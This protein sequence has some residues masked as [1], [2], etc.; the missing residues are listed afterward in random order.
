M[1]TSQYFIGLMSGT[2][3]D[4]LDVALVEVQRDGKLSLIDFICKPLPKP[5]SSALASMSIAQQV[6]LDQLGQVSVA[7]AKL[8]ASACLHIIE[9]NH[10]L[11]E[12]ITAIGSH[13]V[14]VRHRPNSEHSFS[15]QITDPNTLAALTG[16]D[17]IADFRGM[18]IAHQG[19]GAPLVPKFHQVLLGQFNQQFSTNTDAILANLGG[20]ANISVL[21][22]GQGV[23]G[24]DTGPANTLMNLWCQQHL[25]Q[26]FDVDGEWAATGKVC[27][28]LL[29]KMLQ[30]A[31]FAEGWPKS[32]GKEKFNLAWLQGHLSQLEQALPPQDVQAT[33][34]MLTVQ[35]LA[36]EVTKF[37]VSHLYLCGGGSQNPVLVAA[38]KDALPNHAIAT[39]MALGVDAD[40]LEAMAFAWFAY[41][42]VHQIP[43]NVPEATGATR[44][45]VLGAWYQGSSVQN[46]VL[47]KNGEGQ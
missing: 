32:T 40:A 25:N 44:A 24:Y 26:D 34:L 10:L 38:L 30:D 4:G 2:S 3:L 17:V 45:A 15:L 9:K 23:V 29:A 6:D 22:Q 20:I 41:C 43:A 36:N 46:H 18:D 12:R 19:Q 42:R 14:T 31:Y 16:I 37:N 39:T 7:L 35:S 47:S 1:N 27:Q 21:A 33:L 11:P 8:S 28:A 13:G 5:L